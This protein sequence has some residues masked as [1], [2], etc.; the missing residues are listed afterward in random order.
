MLGCSC[1]LLLPFSHQMLAKVTSSIN[2]RRNI[3]PKG[4]DRCSKIGSDGEVCPLGQSDEMRR[5]LTTRV[6]V[7]SSLWS[8]LPLVDAFMFDFSGKWLRNRLPVRP[9]KLK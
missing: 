3:P 7:K 5:N 2:T 8:D 6:Q 1:L 9:H 4:G